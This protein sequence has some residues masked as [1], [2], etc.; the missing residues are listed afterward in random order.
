MQKVT[1][2]PFTTTSWMWEIV[3]KRIMVQA[4]MGKKNMRLYLKY[5]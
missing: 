2:T 3:G 4:A 5:S 1:E